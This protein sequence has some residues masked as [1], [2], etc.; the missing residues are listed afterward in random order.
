MGELKLVGWTHFDCPYP[1]PK[2]DKE[3]LNKMISLIKEDIMEH[4]YLF[5]GE[6]HQLRET[7]VPVFSNGTCFR[8]SMR[9]WGS[10]MSE[11]YVRK[12]GT[13]MSYMDFYIN[14]NIIPNMPLEMDID[15]TP[16]VVEEESPGC[17]LK[18]DREIAD[19]SIACGMPLL[20]L[21]RVIQRYY[22][23]KMKEQNE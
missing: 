8:A 23:K 11:I 14:K 6:D 17:T 4:N 15:V 22:D 16:A 21:D 18:A 19:Q 5:T 1:T 2:L 10:I 20:T 3:G 7:G 13:Q 12:D 9:C